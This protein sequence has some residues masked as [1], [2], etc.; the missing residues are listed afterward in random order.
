MNIVAE[1]TKIL[2]NSIANGDSCIPEAALASLFKKIFSEALKEA[3]ENLDD[4]I[5]QEYAQDGYHCE[6]RDSRSI[7]FLFGEAT[8]RRRRMKKGDAKGVYALDKELG[9]P[10]GKRYSPEMMAVI[11]EIATS[12]TY[13]NLACAVWKLT[14]I[15]M[16]HQKIAGIVREVGK[17]CEKYEERE[18]REDCQDKKTPEILYI[19]GDG[20]VLKKGKTGPDGTV[21]KET[22]EIHRFQIYEGI[23]YRNDRGVLQ[24]A[25]FFSGLSRKDTLLRVKAFLSGHYD[26]SQTIIISNSDNGVGYREDDFDDLF[27]C[28]KRHDHFLDRYHLNRKLK[29]RLAGVPKELKNKLETGIREH[30]EEQVKQ[31]LDT[32]ESRITDFQS[33]EAHN[34]D[35]LRKYL[36]R[37]WDDLRSA[38]ERNLEEIGNI[39]TCESN[40]RIFTY[41]MKRQG[42]KWS[43]GGGTAMIKIITAMKNGTLRNALMRQNE[44]FKAYH[45][46][47]TKTLQKCVKRAYKTINKSGKNR[48]KDHIGALEGSI[49]VYG[50][51]SSP[52]GALKT[53]LLRG[54]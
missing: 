28:Y 23:E 27:T 12:I 48:Y 34:I 29:E 36:K 26:L 33:R 54:Y 38:K 45:K 1:I 40:H 9:I 8:F 15:T 43:N 21:L 16:S 13:R 24:G 14:G 41:R 11:A 37:N 47:A 44:D 35:K 10:S 22:Q 50:P 49:A 6:G 20:V 4:Q 7:Q 5:C 25:H 39:G 46:E 51:S 32:M 30:D 17:A 53:A 31:A 42:R 19:E 3:L 18:A 52:M 2:K